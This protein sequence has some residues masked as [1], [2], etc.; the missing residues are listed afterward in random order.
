MRRQQ[1]KLSKEFYLVSE[2]SISDVF[3]LYSD[4]KAIAVGN[5]DI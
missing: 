5:T 2:L 4:Q 3:I 1:I